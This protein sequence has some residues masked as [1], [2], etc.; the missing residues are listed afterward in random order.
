MPLCDCGALA[1]H[2]K[3][4][5][6]EQ[7]QKWICSACSPDDFMDKDPPQDKLVRFEQ[8][9]PHLYQKIGDTL[10]AKDEL[11]ADTVAAMQGSPSE[12]AMEAARERRRRTR[13]TEPMTQVEI[14]QANRR[15]LGTQ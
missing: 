3:N 15:W 9:F 8:A 13:R 4:K 10:Y 5:N 6:A 2:V 11:T 7:T 14:E 12:D 1:A